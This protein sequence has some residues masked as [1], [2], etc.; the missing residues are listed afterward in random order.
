MLLI[1]PWAPEAMIHQP[2]RSIAP[3]GK[4]LKGAKSPAKPALPKRLPPEHYVLAQSA[5]HLWRWRYSESPELHR[6]ST[7]TG[8][9]PSTRLVNPPKERY[10]RPLVI[11]LLI[12]SAL[13]TCDS[14]MLH[15][16][17][18]Q[19]GGLKQVVQMW[20]S[21]EIES[22]AVQSAPNLAQ[23]ALLSLLVLSLTQ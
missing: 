10:P 11:E 22:A 12:I 18:M 9:T 20:L 8:T 5:T 13:T 1:H 19:K 7:W 6:S 15:P 17:I 23:S 3:S 14:C 16:G 21:F 2:G 4:R